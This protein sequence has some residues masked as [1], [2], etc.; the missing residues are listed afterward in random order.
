MHSNAE[1]VKAAEEVE[2]VRRHV[3]RIR[4]QIRII[5]DEAAAQPDPNTLRPAANG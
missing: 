3:A 2:R 4:A 5:E 1:E